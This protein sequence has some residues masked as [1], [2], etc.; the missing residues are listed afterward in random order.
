M[1]NG[2]QVHLKMKQRVQ[3]CSNKSV[4][5]QGKEIQKEKN[6]NQDHQ[7]FEAKT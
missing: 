3:A 6:L 7:N 5:I 1:S 4:R 2:Y